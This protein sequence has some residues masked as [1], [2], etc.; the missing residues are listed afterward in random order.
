MSENKEEKLEVLADCKNIEGFVRSKMFSNIFA[1]GMELVEETATYLDNEGRDAAKELER[2]DA[3]TYAALSMKLTTK[4]MQIASWLLVLRAVR[5]GEMS[6]DEA[7][8]DKY[9]LGSPEPT[10]ASEEGSPVELTT[11]PEELLDLRGQTDLLYGRVARI[12]GDLFVTAEKAEEPQDAM[13]QLKSLHEAFGK[14]A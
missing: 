1:E 3:L 11:L 8:Q 12:D 2:S 5:E 14:S 9:R 10:Y 13:S 4:L 6:Y 7:A